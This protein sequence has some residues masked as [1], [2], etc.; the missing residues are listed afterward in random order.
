MLYFA[1]MSKNTS[2]KS[3]PLVAFQ[4]KL[5]PELRKRIFS[6]AEESNLSASDIASMALNAGIDRVV[7]K[8]TEIRNPD[9]EKKAA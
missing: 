5:R 1:S 9:S 3:A 7:T 4:I 6:V 2:I 8:L